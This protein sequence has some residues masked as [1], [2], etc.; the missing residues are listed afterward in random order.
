MFESYP[1]RIEPVIGQGVAVGQHQ[2]Q[3]C[4][5]DVVH[6]LSLVA[7]GGFAEDCRIKG[8]RSVDI[9]NG[10]DEVIDEKTGGY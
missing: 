8:C 2:K 1:F 7:I 9:L 10:Q 4:G 5:A 3:S 6:D